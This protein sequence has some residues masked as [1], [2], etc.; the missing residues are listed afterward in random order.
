MKIWGAEEMPMHKT[1]NWWATFTT[2]HLNGLD[3]G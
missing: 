1:L 2:N 3:S